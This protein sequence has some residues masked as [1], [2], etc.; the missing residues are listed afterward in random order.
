MSALDL[1]NF[2][3]SGSLFSAGFSLC[4][5]QVP[6]LPVLSMAGQAPASADACGTC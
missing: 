1:E 2:A 4:A 3:G 5:C 6:T